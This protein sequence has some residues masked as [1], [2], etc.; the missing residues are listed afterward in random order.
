MSKRQALRIGNRLANS[1]VVILMMAM[2]NLA[3]ADFEPR[4][5]SVNEFGVSNQD[6]QRQLAPTYELLTGVFDRHLLRSIE[7]RRDAP[8]RVLYRLNNGH[9]IIQL[10]TSSTR[11]MQYTY[12]FAHELSHIL[13]NFHLSEGVEKFKWFEE[14]LAELASYYVLSEYVKQPPP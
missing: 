2:S 14:T 4:F 13:T 11:Y 12:Q 6:V 1:L 8:P 9:R 5:A 7:F 10:N 3:M